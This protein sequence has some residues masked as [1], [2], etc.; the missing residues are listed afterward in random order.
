MNNTQA[1]VTPMELAQAAIKL[2]ANQ[3]IRVTV[4][5]EDVMATFFV[6][7]INFFGSVCLI[8]NVDVGGF[9]LII[10]VSYYYAD[11]SEIVEELTTYMFEMLEREYEERYPWH[12]GEKNEMVVSMEAPC[13]IEENYRG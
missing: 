11:L 2:E 7:R 12:Q 3:A 1:K 10:D 6:G 13:P 5:N 8:A 4:Q 9:P